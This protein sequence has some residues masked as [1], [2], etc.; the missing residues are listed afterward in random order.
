[1]TAPI[2]QEEQQ[3]VI[4]QYRGIRDELSGLYNKL[5]VVDADRSEHEYVVFISLSGEANFAF[6]SSSLTRS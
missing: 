1:M 6:A 3:R 5:S 2:S 4:S